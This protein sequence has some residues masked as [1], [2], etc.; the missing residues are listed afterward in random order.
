[1]FTLPSLNDF[2]PGSKN[3]DVS[4]QVIFRIHE[5]FWRQVE[6]VSSAH[7]A[8]IASE[9]DEVARIYRDYSVPSDQ[10]TGFKKCHVRKLITD[11]LIP[12]FSL[13]DLCAILPKKMH[14]LDGLGY[15]DDGD[16]V[17]DGG[18]AF[19]MGSTVFYGQALEGRVKALGVLRG[20]HTLVSS[21]DLAA[22]LT[23][24]MSSYSVYLVDWC[25][26][27]QIQAEEASIKSHL[28]SMYYQ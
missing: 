19:D 2:I 26:V 17:I 8:Q 10:I 28:E 1:M 7:D 5:D 11:P 20:H 25:R 14:Q 13:A 12:S 18:F 9:F 4:G 22:A 27:I 23:T 21:G 16:K 3:V 24:L 15:N 6:F